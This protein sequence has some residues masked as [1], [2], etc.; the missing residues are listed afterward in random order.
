MS[1]SGLSGSSGGVTDCSADSRQIF[2]Q[3]R[4]RG[5]D[6]LGMLKP[7]YFTPGVYN[8]SLVLSLPDGRRVSV[9]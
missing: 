3:P 4:A 2:S 9:I 7:L 6:T 8:K 5:A 1:S